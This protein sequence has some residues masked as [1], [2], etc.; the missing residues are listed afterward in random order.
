M[1][2]L[3]VRLNEDG[4]GGFVWGKGGREGRRRTS[5][6]HRGFPAGLI[7]GRCRGRSLRG[8]N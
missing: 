7:G 6:R 4:S 2:R 8:I 5:C 1:G 3:G